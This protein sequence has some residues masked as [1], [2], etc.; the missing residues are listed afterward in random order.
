MP[1]VTITGRAWDPGQNPVPAELEP[2]LFFEINDAQVV[3]GALLAD[4]ETQATLNF[5]TGQFS[6]Q[7]FSDLTDKI[8]YRAVMDHLIPG[9]E[10]EPP[11]RRARGHVYWPQRIYPDVGGDIGDLDDL[12]IGVGLVAV[13][14]GPRNPA[15]RNQ[16]HL[17]PDTGDLYER[18]VSW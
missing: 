14:P 1:L 13:Y 6:V 2:R 5:A 3:S 9:Q 11:A 16:L 12:V 17:N 18:N 10:T 4:V 15:I 7:V 8:W